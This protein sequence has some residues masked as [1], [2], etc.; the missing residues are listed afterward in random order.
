MKIALLSDTR[1]PTDLNY[2]GHGLG[3]SIW[4]IAV[5]LARR[6]HDVTVY[7]GYGSCVPGCTVV[8]SAHE[9]QRA[10]WL[11]DQP[12]AYDVIL[13]GSHQF[14]LA[15]LKPEWP[16]ACKV[17]D[18]EGKAP[19]R[20][21]YGCEYHADEHG[22]PGG[23]V[24]YEGLD[25]EP[26]PFNPGPRDKHL[27]C[28]GILGANW[29]RYDLAVETAHK[30]GREIWLLGSNPPAPVDAD[31]QMQIGGRP[32]F[33]GALGQ[34]AAMITA[35]PSMSLLEGAAAGTP[36]LS[37]VEDGMIAD[38]VTGFR[39]DNVNELA[40][41][42]EQLGELEP[43]HIREW[44]VENRGIEGMAEQWERILERT[45]NREVW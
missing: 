2:P 6:G 9:G 35:R 22:E 26:I 10:F 39:R 29:K 12:L 36:S 7:G 3:R 44:V 8:E 17:V 28:V 37:L 31:R 5:G 41:C 42:C 1:M 16:I 34:A 4:R 43:R 14:Q 40:A 38:S 45:A 15:H 11:A 27:L 24:I 13:D 33:Y 30:A 21:V 23:M 20:R 18:M 19:Y 32:E 25:V